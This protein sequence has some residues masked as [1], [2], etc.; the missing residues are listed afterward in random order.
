E[1][2]IVDSDKNRITVYNFES[3]DT[4]EYSFSDIV[5]SGIY[6]ELSINFA[7]WSF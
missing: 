3:E 5:A 7:E 6:P 2:W 4:I 1:Y